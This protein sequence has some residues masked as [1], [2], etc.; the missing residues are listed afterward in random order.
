MD[1][2]HWAVEYHRPCSFIRAAMPVCPKCHSKMVMSCRE[3]NSSEPFIFT[4]ECR[5]CR[6]LFQRV[7]RLPQKSVHSTAAQDSPFPG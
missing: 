1:E 7:K 5:S 3:A 6:F 2:T 4:F